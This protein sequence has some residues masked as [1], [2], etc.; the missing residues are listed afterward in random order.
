M[1]PVPFRHPK[2]WIAC[3]LCTVSKH[4]RGSGHQLCDHWPLLRD[5]RPHILLIVRLLRDGFPKKYKTCR[6]SRGRPKKTQGNWGHG[7]QVARRKRK[8][9]NVIIYYIIRCDDKLR[10]IHFGTPCWGIWNNRISTIIKRT[11]VLPSGVPKARN[12]SEPT[13]CPWWQN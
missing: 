11:L 3:G 5:M 10:R 2:R 9:P 6:R 1:A 4:P 12:I 13:R 8:R 7:H